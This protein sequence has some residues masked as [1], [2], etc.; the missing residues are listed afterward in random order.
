MRMEQFSMFFLVCGCLFFMGCN[1][2]AGA[3][4]GEEFKGAASFEQNVDN[5]SRVKLLGNIGNI[6]IK[7]TSDSLL[8]VVF[9]KVVKYGTKELATELF[10]KVNVTARNELDTVNIET[11]GMDAVKAIIAKYKTVVDTE[12]VI[13]EVNYRVEVPANL[14]R[15]NISTQMGNITLIDL[16]GGFDLSTQMGN[17]S[18]QDGM[19]IIEK[20][21]VFTKIGNI[22]A[23]IREMKIP[24]E[25]HAETNTGDINLSLS[26]AINCTLEIEQFMPERK[27]TI[28]HNGGGAF[29]KAKTAMGTVS[30]KF[31]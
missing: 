1:S 30:Y 6:E 9:E 31:Y 13:F 2:K 11:S 8:K 22:D 20:S 14:N 15:L 12:K 25:F 27:Q 3:N 24:A 18:L 5:L 16:T 28:Q 29:I 10:E 7:P 4:G 21:T 26:D 19:G 17:I 23:R